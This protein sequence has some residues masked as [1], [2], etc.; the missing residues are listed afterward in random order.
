MEYL[1]RTI[2]EIIVAGIAITAFSLLLFSFNFNIKDRIVRSFIFIMASVVIVFTTEAFARVADNDVILELCL[3]LQWVGIILLPPMYLHF[4]DALLATTGKPS[5]WKR[6]W[7]IR[8]TYLISIFLLIL[9]ATGD[10]FGPLVKG[11]SP[12]AYLKPTIWTAIYLFYYIIIM[13]LTWINFFRTFRRAAT[14]ASKRRMTYLLIGSTAPALGSFS[15]LLLNSSVAVSYS[16]AFWITNVIINILVGSF[17]VIMAYAVSFFGVNWPDR[18][19]KSR[20]M[21][22]LLRGP[23]TASIALA[24]TTMIRR[25]GEILGQP[26]TG[27]VPISLVGTIL[28]MEFVVT[29]ISPWLQR[30]LFYGG[31]S[32]DLLLIDSIEN[33]LLTRGD[34]AQF[35]EMTLSAFCDHLQVSHAE[36]VS[37][38]GSDVVKISEVGD[39][40]Y[41]FNQIEQEAFIKIKDNNAKEN[42]LIEKNYLLL[43]I[44]DGKMGLENELLG[45]LICYP[46][47]DANLLE[48]QERIIKTLLSRICMALQDRLIQEQLFNSL[49][50]LSPQVEFI[51]Q[52]RAAG[53]YNVNGVLNGDEQMIRANLGHWVKEALDHFWGGPQLSES[54]LIQL[55]SVQ[56][57]LQ[58]H[59]FNPSNALRAILRIAVDSLK[60]EGERKFTTEWILFNLIEQKFIERK[61]VRDIA[62]RLAISEADF[63]RKQRIALQEIAKSII[64][65]EALQK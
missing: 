28:L 30:K 17:M 3:K 63:Y 27:W 10:L 44:H 34:L 7:A 4:S 47:P 25:A 15:L 55:R 50:Q 1:F 16:Q 19:I 11:D 13:V 53:R 61:K 52:L 23:I 35:L 24:I 41:E 22:W 57:T 58:Q 21:R 8:G 48:D 26:Y 37:I 42:I 31:D 46:V 60:P 9:M 32:E 59:E 39:L 54:P 51:Q 14:K 64:E 18:V 5:K 38:Q 43:K 45:Y 62:A 36:I 56:N 6:R 29:I 2:S 33:R 20:L 65:N 40:G 49:E 12:T